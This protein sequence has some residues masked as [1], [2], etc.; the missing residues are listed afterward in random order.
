MSRIS[1][2]EWYRRA[3][4]EWPAIVPALTAEEAE[5]ATR[6][7][8]RFATGITMKREIRI[9]SGNRSTWIA[10]DGAFRVNPGRGW[11]SLVH[12]VSHFVWWWKHPNETAHQKDHALLERRMIKEVIKRGWLNGS[13][14]TVAPTIEQTREEQIQVIRSL[15]MERM[16]ARL[17]AW[18]TKAKRA[19]TAIRKLTKQIRAAERRAIKE[20]GR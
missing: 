9:T 11:M 12:N 2:R 20:D 16:R 6:K 7:L 10:R 5:K 17:K 8:F 15:Q 13:L 1:R 3:N 14:K 4:A 18:N 19:E